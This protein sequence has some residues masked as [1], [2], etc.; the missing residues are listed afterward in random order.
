MSQYAGG[1]ATAPPPRVA[2]TW[3]GPIKLGPFVHSTKYL[4]AA[5]SLGMR[6]HGYYT[7]GGTKQSL[8]SDY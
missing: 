5:Q 2:K 6:P 1:G 8:L 3:E 7:L 4:G